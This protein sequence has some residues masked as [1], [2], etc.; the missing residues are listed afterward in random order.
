MNRLNELILQLHAEGEPAAAPA[1]ESSAVLAT[2]PAGTGS[3]SE[4]KT[5]PTTRNGEKATFG[6]KIDK[7]TGRRS[8]VMIRD[9]DAEQKGEPAVKQTEPNAAEPAVTQAGGESTAN[10]Q[11]N[12]PQGTGNTA[13]QQLENAGQALFGNNDAVAPAPY[14]DTAEL[15]AAIQN[16]TVD[17]R[18]IPMEQA[19]AYANYKQQMQQQAAQQAAQAA[20]QQQQSPEDTVY[21]RKQFF[22]RVEEAAR[23][24]TL[25]DLNLTEE[26]LAT[27]EYTDDMDLQARA[28]QFDASLAWNRSTIMAQVQAAQQQ[29]L[30]ARA[31]VQ[32]IYND[33][34]AKVAEYTR[35]EPEWKGIN[36]LMNTYFWKMPHEEAVKYAAAINAYKSGN[37]TEAQAQDLQEYYNKTRIAYYAKK[38]NLGTVNNPVPA[39]PKVEKPG[40]GN[41]KL[42][43]NFITKEQLR[44]ASDYRQ[45]RALIGQILSRS[46]TNK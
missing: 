46:N 6:L 26:Q 39:V 36:I 40:S 41:N 19:F 37:I 7:L 2:E 34:N 27:A 16:N 4:I 32:Q 44:N 45:R 35:T 10:Q 29:A 38:N 12:E 1:V 18:R 30:S 15:L 9:N 23:Q 31:A 28:K 33:I 5:E 42:Q 3:T 21:A 13:Q 20:A 8:V 25:K 14:R 43:E 17:E 11:Q 24:A 22:E